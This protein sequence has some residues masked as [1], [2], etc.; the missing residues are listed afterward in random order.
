MVA[1]IFAARTVSA[2]A[3]LLTGREAGSD[4]LQL[5]SELYLEVAGMDSVAVASELARTA[6]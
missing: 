4:R 3:A 2:L 6:P 1:D 5:V